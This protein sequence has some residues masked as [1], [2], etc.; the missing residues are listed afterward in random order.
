MVWARTQYI[1]GRCREEN[2][3]TDNREVRVVSSLIDTC[4][5]YD[6]EYTCS[7]RYCT[8]WRTEFDTCTGYA[9]SRA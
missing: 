9:N 6:C 1:D 7:Y 5:G 2:L 3:R 4:H 8:C